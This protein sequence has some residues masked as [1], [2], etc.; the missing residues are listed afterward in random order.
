MTTNELL[1]KL[2]SLKDELKQKFGIEEMAL[3]GSYARGEA[4]EDSDI[5]I[6]VLSQMISNMIIY[7]RIALLENFKLLEKRLNVL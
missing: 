6:A 1:V 4:K 2:D 3:F 7:H 5:D